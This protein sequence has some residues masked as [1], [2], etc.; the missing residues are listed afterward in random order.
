MT[1]EPVLQTEQRAMT[2]V[3]ASESNDSRRRTD[4]QNVPEN[5]R[6][7]VPFPT[8]AWSKSAVLYKQT[9]PNGP[10]TVGLPMYMTVPTYL[11]D[12]RALPTIVHKMSRLVNRLLEA[13]YDRPSKPTNSPN[14]TMP[15][16]QPDPATNC[17]GPSL[18]DT[19]RALNTPT[20][21]QQG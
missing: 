5:E 7:G 8:L 13:S 21:L 2:Y 20:G 16:L 4:V 11:D 18:L 3:R 9:Q 15:A 1:C 12:Y 10:L 14:D 19:L 6:V 17:L